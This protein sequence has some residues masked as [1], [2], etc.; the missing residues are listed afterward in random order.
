M[1]KF[2]RKKNRGTGGLFSNIDRTMS[3]L[4]II[5]AERE[6]TNLAKYNEIM[7]AQTDYE[8][9]GEFIGGKDL[10]ITDR[11]NNMNL[12]DVLDRRKKGLKVIPVAWHR[13]TGLWILTDADRDAVL[14]GYLCENCL[15]WQEVP[16]M[17]CNVLGRDFS[18]GYTRPLD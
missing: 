12:A 1:S 10:L 3:E 4:E 9:R 5:N 14:S 16:N 18:C 6:E 2:A 11:Q 13:P 17:K 7:D 15:E 8:F